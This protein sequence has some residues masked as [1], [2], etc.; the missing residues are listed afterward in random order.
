MKPPMCGWAE[1]CGDC[2]DANRICYCNRIPHDD[3][4]G[5]F[6]VGIAW[7]LCPD[8]MTE[9]GNDLREIKS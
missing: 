4:C 5:C 7:H 6:R 9:L 3:G 1:P 2:Q 8:H